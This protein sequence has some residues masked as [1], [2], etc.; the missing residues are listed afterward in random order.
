[1]PARREGGKPRD[2][3]ARDQAA[4]DQAAGDQ[5]AGERGREISVR[6][7]PGL[8]EIVPGAALPSEMKICEMLEVSRTVVREAIRMLTGKGLVES[9]AKSGPRVRP[10]A[11]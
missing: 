3:V 10:L 9:R 7:V 4:G 2:E 6:G 1:M 11:L 5:A 8:P